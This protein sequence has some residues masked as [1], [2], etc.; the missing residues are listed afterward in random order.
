MFSSLRSILILTVVILL[1]SCGGNSSKSQEQKEGIAF[2]RQPIQLGQRNFVQALRLGAAAF[3][4]TA[5][6]WIVDILVE[7]AR[8]GVASKADAGRGVAFVAQQFALAWPDRVSRL[9]FFN[10]AYP[11][12]G[13]QII[14]SLNSNDY[15]VAMACVMML[16]TLT[17]IGNL[18]ADIL[19]GWLD[20]RI[21]FR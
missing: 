14:K 1:T 18:I 7:T 13:Q 5:P 16:A 19:Y 12:I 20:P 10:C 2:A 6:A 17:V 15:S 9:F 8:T 11:G 4:P 3:V 21:P